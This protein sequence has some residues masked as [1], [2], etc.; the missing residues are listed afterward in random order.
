MRKASLSTCRIED[1]E[2]SPQSFNSRVVFKLTPRGILCTSGAFA[3]IY[4][5]T[6][7][8]TISRKMIMP[9]G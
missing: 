6:M 2:S 7:L 8:V 5:L 3:W 9:L 1:A 4:F